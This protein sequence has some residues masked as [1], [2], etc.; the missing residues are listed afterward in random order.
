[1]REILRAAAGRDLMSLA[2]GLP[3]EETFPLFPGLPGGWAQYG[4][5]EGDAPLRDAIARLLASRGLECPAGRILVLNGSQQGLDLAAKLFV[6]PGSPVLCESPTYLAALQV[7]R[8]FGARLHGLPPGTHGPVPSS[9]GPMLAQ[10]GAR[11]AYAV[12]T[13]QNPTGVVWSEESREALARAADVQGCA[14]LE[15]DPYCEIGFGPPVPAPICSRLRNAPWIYLGSFSKSF[16][17]GLRMGFLAASADLFVYLERLK[18]AA[19]LHSNRLSQA[20]VLQDLLDPARSARLDMVRK[21]YRR[22]RDAFDS[23]LH[24]HFPSGDWTAPEGGLFFWARLSRRLDLREVFQET[25]EAGVAFLPGEHCFPGEAEPGWARLNFSHCAP[26]L[27]DR[28][29]EILA[30]VVAGAETRGISPG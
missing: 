30:C 26:E 14:I 20:L 29:L 2:G 10:S 7:F 18:Q 22:R 12:P 28:A 23:S 25:L 16:V 8:L 1:V 17:P 13:Y 21:E 3:A 27:A 5:T 19:D 24:R 4:T 9:I 6:D 11:L 15:D